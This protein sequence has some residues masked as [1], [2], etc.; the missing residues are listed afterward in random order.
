[1]DKTS[2]AHIT[3]GILGIGA[4]VLAYSGIISGDDCQKIYYFIA[5]YVFKNGYHYA[6]GKKVKTDESG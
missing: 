2:L 5:G 1:M 4:T 6:N 3:V